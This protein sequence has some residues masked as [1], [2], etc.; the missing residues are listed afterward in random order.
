VAKVRPNWAKQSGVMLKDEA[1]RMTVN[2]A[3]RGGAG[4]AVDG[5]AGGAGGR[6]SQSSFH[7]DLTPGRRGA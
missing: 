5:G 7:G 4:Q 1:R 6:A 3:L 2:F